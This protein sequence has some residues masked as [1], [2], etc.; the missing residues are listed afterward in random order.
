MKLQACAFSTSRF[1]WCQSWLKTNK[2]DY[3]KIFP[4]NSSKI[5]FSWQKTSARCW[6][7]L[8]SS[9]VPIPQSNSSCLSAGS[10]AECSMSSKVVLWLRKS[11]KMFWYS[12]WCG[13]RTSFGW[14]QTF[15]KYLKKSRMKLLVKN[16]QNPKQL[17]ARLGTHEFCS[18]WQRLQWINF[19]NILSDLIAS[20]WNLRRVV[21][22]VDSTRKVDL[23]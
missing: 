15:C 22:A 8:M 4:M 7:T 19:P 12:G 3:S 20:C 5:P 18:C 6:L 16:Y 14:L 11:D 10:F 17:T 1:Q 23:E 9:L 2:L 21:L 13:L